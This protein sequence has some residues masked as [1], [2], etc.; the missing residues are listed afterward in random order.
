MKFRR[1]IEDIAE[2]LQN[3]KSRGK[4]CSLLVG[5]GCSIKAG[6]PLA[7][8]FVREIEA[9]YCRAYERAEAKTYPKCMAE[10]LLSERRDL[11]AEYVDKAKINWAHI[12]IAL[13]IQAGYV[14]RILTT[15]FDLLVVRACA[16]LG[17]FPAIYD[18]A[19]SQ[20][21]K[22]ADIPPKAV[23][24]LHGQ[25]T[26][27][28]LINTE[29]DFQKHSE[30][31]GP[32]FEDAG[33]GRAWIVVGY[34]GEN[35][36]VFDHLAK[37]KQFDNG[38]FWICYQD[39][40]P[41]PHVR[42]QLLLPEKYAFYNNGFDADSFFIELTQ[43]LGLFPPAFISQPFTHLDHSMQLLTP[44]SL[45]GEPG[46]K[47]VT[48]S[49]RQ[50]IKAAIDKFEKAPSL[51]VD[52]DASSDA[53]EMLGILEVTAQRLLMAGDYQG[54]LALKDQYDKT[55]S[56]DLADVLSL[57]YAMRGLALA[58]Q[59]ETKTGE[60][61]DALFKL[62]GEKF[63]EA[64]KIKPDKHEAFNNWGNA[65][66]G[67]AKAKTGEETEA[68]FKLAGEK[69]QEALKIKPDM[70][71]A[72]YN[73]GNALAEQARGKTGEEAEA[74]LKLAGEKF[75][76]ALK[77][78][79]DKHE[80]LN[81]WG[82]VLTDQAKAKTGEEA[83]ALLKLAG[84]KY[85]EALKIKPDKHEAFNNW[86]AAL[87]D[88]AK[89]KT[90]EE[91][92]AL[93]KLAGEK[94]QE[95]LKIKPD[96]HGAL[97]NWGLTLADQAKAKTGE[98]AE[99]LLKLAGEKY[100]EALKI[101]PDMHE[102][103]NNWGAALTHQAKAKTG[104]EADSLFQLAGEKF[105]EALKIKPDKHEA[106]NNWVSALLYQVRT[107]V[108]EEADTLFDLAMTKLL[109]AEKIKPGSGSYNL[110]CWHALR[111]DE[112]G[113]REWLEKGKEYGELPDR[114]HILSDT[115]LESVRDKDWFK[116]LVNG[117]QAP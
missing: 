64:L 117:K 58:T 82:N 94:Y 104:D 99:A 8:G 20:L 79:P 26:G 102:A 40:E 111:G 78:K 80:A 54:V 73:W 55:P 89:A 5:A 66:A 115:D 16:M 87:A 72:F 43:K 90:G 14:D 38:L 39:N 22:G 30:L 62:A 77:I 12:C 96:M 110:A 48:H 44:F 56:A 33:R 11:I 116:M 57:A 69:Y 28:V 113:C 13:L 85:Q 47:D 41:A 24:Y 23:F 101:K 1:S 37:V 65:L 3:A 86:G 100:Q 42:E 49:P 60:E 81:N 63:Q 71:T 51:I 84:E 97:N 93:L 103:L 27:F 45:P 2:T 76:E 46:E 74:L 35:D 4:G 34:S 36:P 10:L 98:E 91:A 109:E 31:L 9:R 107:K 83:E 50:W 29:E 25:Y 114:A 105:Q 15:N 70:H 61:A 68:L 19:A 106:L 32:V 17:E 21:F 6:I 95:A 88:Q 53:P 75:Q 18:F 67:Q 108:G 112:Q 59:A 52:E 92:E 7:S